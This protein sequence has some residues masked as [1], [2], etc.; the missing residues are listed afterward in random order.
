MLFDIL[1]LELV[2]IFVGMVN[3]WRL[4]GMY[5]F[6]LNLMDMLVDIDCSVWNGIDGN[7]E[8]IYG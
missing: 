3:D 4:D 6:V 2:V 5:L 7:Y 1:F 8:F